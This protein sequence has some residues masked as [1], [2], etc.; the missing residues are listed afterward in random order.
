MPEFERQGSHAAWI[1]SGVVDLRPWPPLRRPADHAA[2][3]LQ[4]LEHAD[5][6]GRQPLPESLNSAVDW[7]S[8]AAG[9]TQ[10]EINLLRRDSYLCSHAAAYGE[11]ESEST[12]QHL[13]E[14][15]RLLYVC[16]ALENIVNHLYPDLDE[17][18]ML[19]T[20]R[21]VERQSSTL[22][23]LMQVLSHL[24]LHVLQD[25]VLS[26]NAKLK[27]A[28][29]GDLDKHVQAS[30]V[31]RVGFQMRHSFAHG[32]RHPKVQPEATVDSGQGRWGQGGKE[33]VCLST[34]GTTC[35]L[36]AI[37]YILR[38]VIPTLSIN[39]SSAVQLADDWWVPSKN[40]TRQYLVEASLDDCLS[41]LHLDYD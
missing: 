2:S 21:A 7:L 35:L 33:Q 32:V 36:F 17:S 8:L 41:L 4:W 10:I 25:P 23:Y 40:G 24:E 28:F 38:S 30:I 19:L 3:L 11:A 26:N 22:P 27:R 16:C 37:Q 15:T 9:L 12:S 14:A 6:M 34:L 29:T 18:A 20:R 1:E 39:P 5:L 31:T 13:T